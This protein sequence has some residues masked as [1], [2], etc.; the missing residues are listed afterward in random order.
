MKYLVVRS[1]VRIILSIMLPLYIF[2]V[3]VTINRLNLITV[4]IEILVVIVFYKITENINK[5][6][7]QKLFGSH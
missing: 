1:T 6:V 4:F 3:L 7:Q 2:D 5:V